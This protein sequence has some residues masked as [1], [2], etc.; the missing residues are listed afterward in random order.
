M[1]IIGIAGGSGSGKTTITEKL[2]ET[3]GEDV[4]VIRHDD[5]YKAQ[6][7]KTVEERAKQNY[8]CPDA[9]DT[10]F[11]AEQIAVLKQGIAIDCPVYDYMIHDRSDRVRRI[12]P[13]S[14]LIIDGILVLAEASLRELMDVKIYVDTDADV[15]ILR[16]IK[17]DVHERNRTMDSVINQ[18][19]ATVKPMHEAYVEPSKK[20]ADV[21]I[22]EGGYN[23][24]ALD[25]VRDRVRHHLSEKLS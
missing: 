14:V 15:R 1:L 4:A 12:E 10:A 8:D 2:V 17:R 24:V 11:M 21:I 19:M 3:F 6:H 18:Y 7:E 13:R 25:M 23:L 16:R 20:Y 9:F 22:P 5:Y